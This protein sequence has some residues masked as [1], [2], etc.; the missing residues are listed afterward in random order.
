[1]VKNTYDVTW[2]TYIHR[3]QLPKVFEILHHYKIIIIIT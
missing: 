1:M 2:A 3:E